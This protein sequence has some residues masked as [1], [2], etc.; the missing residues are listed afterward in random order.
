MSA[1]PQ[2]ITNLT[3][4]LSQFPISRPIPRLLHA[5][6]VVS[7]WTALC[8]FVAQSGSA[9]AGNLEEGGEIV[10]ELIEQNL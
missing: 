9:F 7:F 3:M 8:Y 5:V 2:G 4:N 10:E 1:E 6:F